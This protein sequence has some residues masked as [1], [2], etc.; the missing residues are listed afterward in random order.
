MA[1]KNKNSTLFTYHTHHNIIFII[2]IIIVKPIYLHKLNHNQPR[3]NNLKFANLRA[4]SIAR[5][6]RDGAERSG[7]DRRRRFGRTIRRIRSK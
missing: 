3:K 4:I 6:Y 7:S 2:I 1:P 5:A